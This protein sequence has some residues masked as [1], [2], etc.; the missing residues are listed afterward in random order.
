MSKNFRVYH[1]VVSLWFINFG[2][3]ERELLRLERHSGEVQIVLQ[4]VGPGKRSLEIDGHGLRLVAL[5]QDLRSRKVS[6]WSFRTLA[7][8]YLKRTIT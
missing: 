2:G 6:Y 4:K 1:V 8:C 3:G 5:V 7:V